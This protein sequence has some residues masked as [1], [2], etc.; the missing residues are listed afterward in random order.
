MAYDMFSA[1]ALTD[2]IQTIPK[3]T[4]GILNTFFRGTKNFDTEYVELHMKKG[5][6]RMAPFCSDN[7]QATIIAKDGFDVLT[8]KPARI[9]MKKN[10]EAKDMQ[11][12]GMGQPI[13]YQGSSSP[14]A[15]L[16]SQIGEDLADLDERIAF[17]EEW[18]AAKALTTG[19]V[20]VIGDGVNTEIDYLFESWQLP[21]LTGTA[22]WTNAA[23][24]PLS[25]L[26]GWATSISQKSGL[27]ADVVLLGKD[28]ANALLKNVNVLKA[29]DNRR[30]QMGLIDISNLAKG[31]RYLGN[32]EGIEIFAYNEW[33]WDGSVDQ[34]MIPDD[35][36]II[37]STQAGSSMY[38]GLVLDLKAGGFVGTRFSKSWEQEDPS[39]RWILAESRPIPSINQVSAYMAPVVV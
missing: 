26:R 36:V 12:R 7:S 3:C 2:A 16:Q 11:V 18:M 29:L 8:F 19:K 35:Q 37:G 13:H 30:V 33:Y 1:Y 22:V 5:K 32:L 4:K 25:D 9:R 31:L 20:P 15:R 17:R 6:R 24:D 38:Y 28:A 39:V 27:V 10:F 34:P 14:N 23:S 21:T